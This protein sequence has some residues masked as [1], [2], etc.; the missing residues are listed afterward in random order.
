MKRSLVILAVTLLSAAA[1][2]AAHHHTRGHHAPGPEATDDSHALITELAIAMPIAA[3]QTQ[4]W[5]DALADLTG[6]RYDEYDAS[7]RRWGITSQTTFLQRTPM[8]DFAVIHLTGADVGKSLHAMSESQDPWDIGW[9][10]LTRSLHGVDFARG[11][12]VRP[13]VEKLYGM[14]ADTTSS[15]RPFLFIAPVGDEAALRA[16]AAQF[17]GPRHDE[18]AAARRRI[19]VQ[20]ESVFLQRSSGGNAVVVYWLAEDPKAALSA[21]MQSD[22][23]VDAEL[24]DVAHAT[25]PLPLETLQRTVMRNVLVAHYPDSRKE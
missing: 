7:R 4:A 2:A 16:L 15:A 20:R 23:P 6:A 14:G 19:G 5:K 11:E 3:G 24:R 8:G 22:L 13:K 9:R 21:L 18:Y 12:S 1:V 25:H 17:A 10:K